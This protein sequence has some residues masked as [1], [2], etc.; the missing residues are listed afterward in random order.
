MG[1][2]PEP[3]AN[4]LKRSFNPGDFCFAK[5]TD[6]ISFSILSA[7]VRMIFSEPPSVLN[8]SQLR[9]VF[10][11]CVCLVRQIKISSSIDQIEIWDAVL[12]DQIFNYD[13]NHQQS[14]EE[15]FD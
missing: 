6:R 13:F 12:L 14:E 11:A 8:A 9:A 2:L 7:G 3:F 1:K 15:V 5:P 10:F 4:Y